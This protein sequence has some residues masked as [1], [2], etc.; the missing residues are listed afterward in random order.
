MTE[1]SRLINQ[2]NDQSCSLVAISE[3]A[4]NFDFSVKEASRVFHGRGQCYE[5]LGFINVDWFHPVVW[6][7]VYG[8]QESQLIEGVKRLFTHIAEQ[9]DHI[10]AV[11][12]Q[13]RL[14]G[15]SKQ[16]LWYGSIPDQVYAHELGVNYELELSANQNIGFFLDAKPARQWLR[17]NAIDKRV[18][19]MFAYT[20]SFSVA[21]LQ[22]LQEG[23]AKHVVNID[24]AKGPIAQGQKNHQLNH[25]DLEKVSF[26]PH[27]IFRSMR[28]LEKR[29]PYDIIVI[30]PPSRQRRSFE[31]DKDYV[32]LLKKL[33]PLM[34]EQTQIL[35]LLNAPYLD[36]HFL[37]QAFAEALPSFKLIKRLTQRDDFPEK[38]LAC[39]LKMQLF[40]Q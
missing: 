10:Q 20:C 23:N 6:I 5:G 33:S 22:G 9:Q 17:K 37:P 27:D 12:F 4:Q 38:D 15:Q 8:E 39:C 36:E 28:N 21:A 32:K 19:N 18:L 26:L 34:H 40:S 31:A 16:E 11:C 3:K 2:P 7:V 13:Q 29:G 35:A 30:D 14:R 25:I 1:R 24:M